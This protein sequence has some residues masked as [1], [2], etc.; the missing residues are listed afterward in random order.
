MEPEKNLTDGADQSPNQEIIFDRG[1][2]EKVGGPIALEKAQLWTKNYRNRNSDVTTSHLFGIEV[3]QKILK[4]TNCAG[5]RI[6][7]A[8][9]D[10]GKRQLILSGVDHYGYDQLPSKKDMPKAGTQ[11]HAAQANTAAF[12][13]D[14][15]LYDQSWPCP[16]TNGC[17][18]NELTES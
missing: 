16:G 8:I 18:A 14:N 2:I 1:K 3:I 17:P 4:Q 11:H 5:I 7:Y 10:A 13:N 6:H 9:D 12:N 15:E